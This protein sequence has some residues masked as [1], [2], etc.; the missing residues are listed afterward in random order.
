MKE[1]NLVQPPIPITWLRDGMLSGVIVL[2]WTNVVRGES[3]LGI[4][5][6]VGFI[7][8]N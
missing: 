2:V 4:P 7:S 6:S 8:A 1:R 5:L 3:S